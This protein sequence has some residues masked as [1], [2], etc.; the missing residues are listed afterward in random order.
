MPTSTLEL[1]VFGGRFIAGMYEL[2]RGSQ[3]T[4]YVALDRVAVGAVALKVD[5]RDD[6]TYDGCLKKE[7]DIYAR[8]GG[9]RHVPRLLWSGQDDD[10]HDAI[11]LPL[12]G[13]SLESV[14]LAYGWMRA[15][16]LPQ[17]LFITAFL[18]CAFEEIHDRGIVHGDIHLGNIMFP[19]QPSPGTSS[20]DET[21]TGSAFLVASIVTAVQHGLYLVDFGTFSIYLN[22][23]GRHISEDDDAKGAIGAVMYRPR[24][25]KR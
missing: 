23:D 16:R 25:A 10:G 2:E 19:R 15:W 4:V 11:A 13:P 7:L 21:S 1:K 12:L 22:A 18:I 14:A 24:S 5:G 6:P 17:V 9:C 20:T 8:V 3:G